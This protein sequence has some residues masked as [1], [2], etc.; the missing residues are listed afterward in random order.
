[1]KLLVTGSRNLT[2]PK[3]GE[4]IGRLI[5]TAVSNAPRH[6]IEVSS[7]VLI[8]GMAEGM[9]KISAAIGLRMGFTTAAYP[10]KWS[11]PCIPGVCESDHRRYNKR[12]GSYCPAA[13]VYRNQE[14]VDLKPDF[15]IV[16][17]IPAS[18]GTF[19]CFQ[20]IKKA[21]IPYLYQTME[22]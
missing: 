21:G 11:G 7:N 6:G 19:D 10:A 8:H 17:P 15:A 9:D 5:Q 12:G 3:H 16:C 1:M 14:M 22:P 18:K 4:I 2:Y 20:R 13:G